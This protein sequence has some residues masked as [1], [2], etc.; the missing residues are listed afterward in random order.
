M[1]FGLFLGPILALVL[2]NTVVFA[3]V[4]R[5]LIKHSCRKLADVEKRKKLQGTIKTLISVISIM[6]MFGLQWLFGAFTIAEASEVFQWLFVI[7]STLQG[8]FL[9]LFFCVLTQDA[10]EEWLNFFSFGHRKKKKR[11]VITSHASQG[12]QRDRNTGSTYITSK[13]SQTLRRGILS[14][15]D[16]DS[17]VEMRENRK[18]FLALPTSIS[19]DK[20][21][22]FIIENGDTENHTS[23]APNGLSTD[24]SSK[25]PPIEVPEHILQRRFMYSYNPATSSPPIDVEEDNKDKEYEDDTVASEASTT[26]CYDISTAEYGDLT[27]LTDLSVITNS[28]VSDTEEISHL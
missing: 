21:T 27:Q 19:D 23:S 5:V 13:H 2:F 7:F 1:F 25:P 16:G 28:D 12:A 11:G 17:V 9:F 15:A 6:F 8:F 4:I 20:E 24:I 3:L 18:K 10:R 26:D 22:V 14:S